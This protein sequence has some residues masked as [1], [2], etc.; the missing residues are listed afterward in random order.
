MRP[1]DYIGLHAVRRSVEVTDAEVEQVLKNEQRINSVILQR[2]GKRIRV[3]QKLDDDFARDFS[4]YDTLDDWKDAI[5]D[6]LYDQREE[7]AEE[8]LVEDL[9]CQIAK[10][11]QICPDEELCR[12]LYEE[13]LQE[14]MAHIAS[15]HLD[16]E[17]YAEKTGRSPE[18]IL[19]GLKEDAAFS[20]CA[21]TILHQIAH[22]QKLTV[23][24]EE[25]GAYLEGNE[26]AF[27]RDAIRDELLMD[28]AMDFV[29][30]HAVIEEDG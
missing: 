23:S 12:G 11:A 6:E 27:E 15:L 8:E 28:A 1:E 13:M 2:D 16:L 14:Q 26:D 22:D 19:N 20:V 18:D 21:Q 4:I 25:V 17:E 7:E 10:R 9:L 29:L 30:A 5:A 3:L 24:E